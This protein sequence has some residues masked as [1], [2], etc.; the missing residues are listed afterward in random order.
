MAV[1]ACLL[2]AQ[3]LERGDELVELGRGG[4]E[5]R[6]HAHTLHV[7]AVDRDGVDAEALE[8]LAR[9]VGGREAVD[10]DVGDAAGARGIAGA[11]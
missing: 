10:A 8:Q 5:V 2:G 7:R 3:F 9:E 11:C 6:S 4:V 1:T